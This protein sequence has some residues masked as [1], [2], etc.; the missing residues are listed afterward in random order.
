MQYQYKEKIDI[1]REYFSCFIILH[2]NQNAIK[3]TIEC[4]ESIKNNIYFKEKYK[5]IIV[6]NGSKDNS[7]KLLR[8]KFGKDSSV[9][10]VISKDNLGF[11]R[12]NNLGCKRAIDYYRPDFLIVI[13][14]DTV[15]NQRDFLEKIKERYNKE[16]FHV[17]GPCIYDRNKSNQNPMKDLII[18]VERID[19][20]LNKSKKKLAELNRIR[21]SSFLMIKSNISKFIYSKFTRKKLDVID[22][23]IKEEIK[24]IGLHGAAL[25]FSKD[26][27]KNYRKIF[28]EGTF[29]YLEE[30]ILFYRILKD[31]LV[32]VYYPELEIFHKEDKSTEAS[33]NK[34]IEQYIFKEKNIIN[35]LEVYKNLILS[36]QNLLKKV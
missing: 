22:N 33:I 8:N 20:E 34:P 3:D 12:G 11:A 2:Y 16:K 14:N 23:S 18:D 6:E 17:L 10:I 30:D 19:E 31:N 25:I 29:L 28:F 4:V 36:E 26:Y 24:N 35:S 15:I 7:I 27:Y 32:S 9:D 21:N 5:I 13:N 1:N